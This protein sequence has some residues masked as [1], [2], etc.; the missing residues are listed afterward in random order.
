MPDIIKK[1]KRVSERLPNKS[2]MCKEEWDPL[3]L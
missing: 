3:P 1:T 2:K